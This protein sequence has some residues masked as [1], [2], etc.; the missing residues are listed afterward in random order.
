MNKTVKEAIASKK[1]SD[2]K[3]LELINSYKEPENQNGSEDSG[4]SDEAGDGTPADKEAFSL[5]ELKAMIATGVAEVLKTQAATQPEIS[6][7]LENPREG[8]PMYRVLK[9]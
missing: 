6:H 2:E 5:V 4:A 1:L 7:K 3:L 9:K 8:K